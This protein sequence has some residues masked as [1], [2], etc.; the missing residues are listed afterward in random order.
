MSNAKWT[1]DNGVFIGRILCDKKADLELL[2][3]GVKVEAEEHWLPCCID[4]R[5]VTLL[6][7]RGYEDDAFLTV[8]EGKGHDPITYTVQAPMHALQEHFV[9]VKSERQ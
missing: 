8:M 7:V 4:L 1:V 6:R 2:D 9:R 3:L 5:E